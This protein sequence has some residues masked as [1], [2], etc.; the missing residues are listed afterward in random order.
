MVQKHKFDVNIPKS[1]QEAKAFDKE[2]GNTLWWDSIFKELKNIR[3]AFEVREKDISELPLGYQ[4]ITCH[5]IFD[6]KMG[7][8]L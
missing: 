8:T 5:K 7:K 1:V 4:K 3:P 6:V 2:N